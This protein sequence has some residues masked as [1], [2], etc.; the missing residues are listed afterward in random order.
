M[1]GILCKY[2]KMINTTYF[3]AKTSNFFIEDVHLITLQ[4]NTLN[5]SVIESITLNI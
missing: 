4:L 3:A 5:L 1:D 2:L